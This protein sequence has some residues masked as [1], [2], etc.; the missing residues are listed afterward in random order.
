MSCCHGEVANIYES[1][2]PPP[3]NSSMLG[4]PGIFTA[5]RLRLLLILTLFPNAR[6][7]YGDAALGPGNLRMVELAREYGSA[8]KFPGSGGAVVGLCL[9]REKKVRTCSLRRWRVKSLILIMWSKIFHLS[10]EK[11]IAGSWKCRLSRRCG[12]RFFF[13]CIFSW[14]WSVSLKRAIRR[15]ALF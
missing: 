7:V 14:F 3:Q 6:S 4:L 11:P 10:Q 12:F 9:D 13:P 1:N 5:G 8:V 15:S 2:P